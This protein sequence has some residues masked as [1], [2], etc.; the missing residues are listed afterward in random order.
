MPA[1]AGAVD[2]ARNP[3]R[4][5]LFRS[6]GMRLGCLPLHLIPWERSAAA[7][8]GE[9]RRTMVPRFRAHE[10]VFERFALDASASRKPAARM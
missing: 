6:D 9:R 7:D 10:I 2:R 4:L 8:D 1:R 3:R 5:H